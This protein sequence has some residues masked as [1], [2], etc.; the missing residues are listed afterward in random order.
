[1]RMTTAFKTKLDEKRHRKL[2]YNNS[3]VTKGKFPIWYPHF[4]L[5]TKTGNEKF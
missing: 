1:M 2:L 3:R 4:E 5:I